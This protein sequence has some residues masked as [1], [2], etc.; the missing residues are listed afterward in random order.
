M[1]TCSRSVEERAKNTSLP[2]LPFNLCGLTL[3]GAHSPKE[4]GSD[5]VWIDWSVY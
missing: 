1:L 5:H 2:I 3:A 4:P